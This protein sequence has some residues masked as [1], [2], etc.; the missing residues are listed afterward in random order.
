[1]QAALR[2]AEKP[3]GGAP[4]AASGYHGAGPPAGRPDQLA[5]F[6]LARARKSDLRAARAV[7]VAVTYRAGP[8]DPLGIGERIAA[9]LVP[10][11]PYA[12]GE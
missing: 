5:A 8:A 2:I 4:R 6:A 10:F 11:W 9:E 1:M 3:R 12:R 7:R